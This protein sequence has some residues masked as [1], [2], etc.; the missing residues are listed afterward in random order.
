MNIKENL[1]DIIGQLDLLEVQH[2]GDFNR[3][4]ILD[5]KVVDLTH[6]IEG[7]V[8]TPNIHPMKLFSELKNVLKE[9]RL[10]K[11]NIDMWEALMRKG[12]NLKLKN[13]REV[14]SGRL[15]K[16]PTTYHNRF[17]SSDF[18]ELKEEL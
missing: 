18:N 12:G 8:D 6:F 7:G 11:N 2:G 5:K 15:N 13:E 9:R 16:L 3:L 4:S 1:I 14:L 10:V 17:Y